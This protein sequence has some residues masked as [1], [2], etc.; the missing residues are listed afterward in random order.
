[1][2]NWCGSPSVSED[3]GAG[4]GGGRTAG[5]ALFHTVESE[6]TL[7]EKKQKVSEAMEQLK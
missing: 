2:Q 3:E 6:Q 7:K 4:G 1:M 5:G